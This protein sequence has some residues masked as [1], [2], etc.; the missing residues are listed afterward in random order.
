MA[1][2]V[3]AVFWSARERSRLAELPWPCR[4]DGGSALRCGWHFGGDLFTKRDHTFV[5]CAYKEN[6][7]LEDTISSLEGQQDAGELMVSTS[8]PNDHI[9]DVCRRHGL[10]LVV[11]PNPHL[12]GD[13]WNYAYRSASTRLV[14]IAH[15]DD[16]YEPNYVSAILDAANADDGSAQIIYTDYYEIRDGSRVDKN[17]L[18][19]I[20]SLLNAPMLNSHMNGCPFFKRRMLSLGNP[21][22]CP[23]ITYVKPNVPEEPFDTTYINS[24]DYKTLVDL[25]TIPGRFVYVPEKLMGHRIYSGSATTKNLHENIRRGEDQEILSMLWPR[26]IASLINRVYAL[27]EKSNQI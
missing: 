15:Q 3:S 20:K 10:R 23:A 6:P 5:V 8:T 26:P 25:A 27:S 2:N 12:A 7:F 21:V 1:N 17:V 18:L 16:L 13:D 11:N 14:T 9:K 4:K 24:C 19:A 22:C